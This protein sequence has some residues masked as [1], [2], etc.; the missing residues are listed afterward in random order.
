VMLEAV[1]SHVVGPACCSSRARRTRHGGAWRVSL[2]AA[3]E[4]LLLRCF[5]VGA[6]CVT[7]PGVAWCGKGVALLACMWC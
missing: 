7:F 5:C 1:H 4:L 6:C 2:H 3:I